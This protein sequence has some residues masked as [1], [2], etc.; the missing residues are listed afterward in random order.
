MSANRLLIYLSYFSA[1][2]KHM[3]EADI[4]AVIVP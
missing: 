2:P 4:Y 3:I 1:D